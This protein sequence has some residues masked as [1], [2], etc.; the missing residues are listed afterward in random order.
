MFN[1]HN[2]PLKD[3]CRQL[4]AKTSRKFHDYL[5]LGG[6]DL[7]DVETLL[8][9]R[10]INRRTH[11]ESWEIDNTA[12]G[13]DPSPLAMAEAS[14]TRLGLRNS[15]VVYGD[16]IQQKWTDEVLPYER[17]GAIGQTNSGGARR[18]FVFLDFCG[19]LKWDRIVWLE[20][21]LRYGITSNAR[22]A[23]TF[24]CAPRGRKD[25]AGPVFHPLTQRYLDNP[26][27]YA[28]IIETLPYMGTCGSVERF[29]NAQLCAIL[30]LADAAGLRYRKVTVRT[31]HDKQPDHGGVWMMF[32]LIQFIGRDRVDFQRISGYNQSSEKQGNAQHLIEKV[33]TM[34][35]KRRGLKAG[36][37]TAKLAGLLASYTRAHCNGNK[38]VKAKARKGIAK[39]VGI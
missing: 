31:Y 10:V 34:A 17:S 36:T 12:R 18:D 14:A 8:K 39:L 33:K 20:H 13:I 23:A 7:L 24:S 1:G 2:R 32:V 6:P 16:I 4:L 21:L 25:I 37:V 5:T 3:E 28:S 9:A 35:N 26:G 19:S 15:E 22:F 11:V 38:D 30:H 29:R 27:K